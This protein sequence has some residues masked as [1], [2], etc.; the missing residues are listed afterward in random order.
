MGETMRDLQARME[1][2]GKQSMVFERKSRQGVMI[3]ERKMND[4][5]IYVPCSDEFER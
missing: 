2:S 3:R 1:A 4:A 5:C